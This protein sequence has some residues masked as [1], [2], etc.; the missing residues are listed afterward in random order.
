MH[1]EYTYISKQIEILY[2]AKTVLI[3]KRHIRNKC[4]RICAYRYQ[5]LYV[6]CCVHVYCKC[7][8]LCKRS[9]ISC[10]HM[11]CGFMS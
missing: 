4:V 1:K 8:I 2:N 9:H 6:I 11:L 3:A 5:V 7:H 10:T